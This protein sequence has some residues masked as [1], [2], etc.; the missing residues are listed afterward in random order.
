MP[1]VSK[2]GN[3]YTTFQDMGMRNSTIISMTIPKEIII[4]NPFTQILMMIRTNLGM[5]TFD[6]MG[7]LFFT[8]LTQIPHGQ[9]D[10]DK[11][12]KILLF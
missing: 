8:I 12:R 1:K 3:I 6:T 2:I 5:Y 7:R 9:P 11:Y 4:L 10:K